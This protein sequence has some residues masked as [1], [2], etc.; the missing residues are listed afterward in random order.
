MRFAF[1]LLMTL[2][3]S[4]VACAS[5]SHRLRGSDLP[6]VPETQIETN[7]LEIW[8]GKARSGEVLFTGPIFDALERARWTARGFRIDGWT[9]KS[10]SGTPADA[11]AVFTSSWSE[12]GTERIATL[13]ILASRVRGSATINVEI[14]PVSKES[15]AS[16]T[17]GSAK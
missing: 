10:L 13:H 2:L 3:V 1:P 5:Q 11:T 12:A 8:Q 17:K 15:D 9:E 14:K 7:S 4:L 16:D 6:R